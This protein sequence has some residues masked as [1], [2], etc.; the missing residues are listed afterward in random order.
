MMTKTQPTTLEI[1]QKGWGA[2]TKT[3][4]Q[5]NAVRFIR[6]FPQGDEDSVEYWKN[7]WT[8]KSVNEIHQEIM[9]AKE[10]KQI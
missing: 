5:D 1:M 2:L 7:L 8:D 10:K 6:A 9:Q 3:L 4:G